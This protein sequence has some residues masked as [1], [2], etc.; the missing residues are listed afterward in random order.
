MVFNVAWPHKVAPHSIKQRV[1][2]VAG[3]LVFNPCLYAAVIWFIGT[4]TTHLLASRPRLK[5]FGWQWKG[6]E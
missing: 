1:A 5:G 2:Y 6:G 4:T 3:K